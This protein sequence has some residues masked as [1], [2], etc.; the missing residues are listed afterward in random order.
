MSEYDVVVIGAG[1]AAYCAALSAEEN[2]ARV[3]MLEA[4]P[5]EEHGGNSRFASGVLRFAFRDLADIRRLVP[6]MSD[7]DAAISDFGS[8]TEEQYLDDMG[9]VTQYRTDPD[10]TEVF[11]RG[12]YDTLAWMHSKGV[13][14]APLFRRQAYK[15]DGRFKFWGGLALE[16][17]GGGPGIVEL[18]QKAAKSRS[19][20]IRY[21]TRAVELVQDAGRV[22]GV[23][24]RHAGREEVI[25]ANAVVLACGG[26]SSNVEWRTR[27]LGPGWDL[28][29]VR[30]TKFNN[31]DGIRMALDVGARPYGHWS[32]CHAVGW[33]RN[34]PEFGDLEVGENFQKHSYP[35]GIMVNAYGKRFV[36]EGADFRNYTYAKYGKAVLEQ[37]GQFAW[38]VFDAKWLPMLREEYRIRRVTKVRADTLEELATKLEDVDPQGFLAEVKRYNAAVREDIPFDPSIKDGRCTVGLEVPKSNWANTISEGPFEAYAITCGVTFTFGGIKIDRSARVLSMEGAPIEGLY[39]AGEMVGGLFYFNYAGGT[40]LV[41]GAV[42]GRIAGAEAARFGKG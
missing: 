5:E 31:G 40:G 35:F 3:L 22:S 34:A 21:A 11:V 27:Y 2:G 7:S 9:R 14:Y 20:P 12:S 30:G 17:W 4:A 18:E 36:D 28:A 13:R 26:F 25:K 8:Y 39:C 37:P 29:K 1:N 10:L 16:S 32:G 42:Y 38:Q 33:D 23:L 24:V 19:I 41:S 15:I 6:E